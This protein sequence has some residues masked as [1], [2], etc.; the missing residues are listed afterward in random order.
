MSVFLRAA[1]AYE[2]SNFLK[3]KIVNNFL[4]NVFDLKK[5]IGDKKNQWWSG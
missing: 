3:K 1:S 5:I 4:N 2:T